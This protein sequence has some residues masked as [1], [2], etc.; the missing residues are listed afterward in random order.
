MASESVATR[1][2]LATQVLVAA[3]RWSASPVGMVGERHTSKS[4]PGARSLDAIVQSVE[5]EIRFEMA[6]PLPTGRAAQVRLLVS[7]T[8]PPRASTTRNDEKYG[9]SR[10]ISPF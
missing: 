2:R 1:D 4:V 6:D 3:R 5:S 9:A 7:I 10:P 8:Q